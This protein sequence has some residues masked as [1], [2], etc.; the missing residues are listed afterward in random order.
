VK[1]LYFFHLVF[2]FLLLGVVHAE[3]APTSGLRIVPV[4]ATVQTLQGNFTL[5][6]RTRL[7]VTDQESY[8]IAAMFNDFLFENHGFRLPIDKRPLKGKSYVVFSEKHHQ[9]LPLEGYRVLVKPGRVVITGQ[10]PG[11]FYGMQ[12]LLQ[13]LPLEMS[14]SFALPAVDITDY[15]RFRYRGVLLDTARHFFPVPSIKKLLDVLAEYKVNEFHWHL[16]DDEA[17]R[18]EIKKYPELTRFF[19]GQQNLDAY[20]RG[21]YTQEQIRDVVAF[22]HARFI[23]IVPEIE[24][25]GHSQT[26]L[27]AYPS[28]G[29]TA[30]RSANTSATVRNDVLCPKEETFN[31][32]QDVLSEVVAL[33]PG[34]YIHIGGDEVTKDSWK[35]SPEAQA[36]MKH[37]GLKNEDE[38]ETYF[39]QRMERFLRSKGK[40][41]IGW[42]E[43][44]EGGLAPNA[45]VMSWRGESGGIAAAK[46]KHDVIMSPTDYCYFDYYQGDPRRE[47]PAIGGFLPLQKVYQYDATPAELTADEQKYILGTQANLWSEY[48]STPEHLQYM[49]FPRLFAFSEVAWSQLTNKD[50]HDFLQRLPYQ[51][52][53][54]EQHDVNYRI[55]E[56]D[57]LR[58][59]YTA[60][61][62]YVNVQLT[63][64]IPGS[65]MHYTLDGS[66]P[67]EQST[68]YN[69]PFQVPLE[70]DRKTLLNVVVV[71]PRG[72]RSEIYGA[73]LLRRSYLDAVAYNGNQPGLA[74][75]L[76]D[77]KFTSTLDPNDATQSTAGRANSFDLAQFGRKVDYGISFD[78]YIKAPDDAFYE[79]AVESDDGGVLKID[80]EEVVNNDGNHG[81]QLAEGYIPLRKGFH[82]FQLR[83]FQGEG[84][85][86]LRV[87]WALPGQQLKPVD[88]SVLYH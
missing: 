80:G 78:G 74:F 54:L 86:S 25:P 46:Q 68:L 37:E 11:L 36:V 38:L 64:L 19:P 17:W 41:T 8:R 57:G 34:P 83:Y 53:R 33:F 62:D 60:T 63:S 35:Q 2:F 48:I 18:I 44:L 30:P 1:P 88:D 69:S 58:D 39:V 55:P 50:Y 65:Q 70:P 67:T 26:A 73:T 51:L 43:I 40:R 20:A 75:A 71:D 29:C 45:I 3:D 66:T 76:F 10:L 22:A 6:D 13:I 24:M 61:D 72:R 21:Y 4:P 14:S 81:N 16:T 49:L 5:N 87:S 42:D 77:G 27:A 9:P 28:L 52:A 82:R 84:D 15:P 47:P 56:P 32:L 12:T 31:F 85:S 59:F 23:N 7:L 79:F